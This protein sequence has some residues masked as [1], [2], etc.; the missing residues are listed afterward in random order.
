METLRSIAFV[1]FSIVCLFWF[2]SLAS[3]DGEDLKSRV[4]YLEAQNAQLS[5]RI[6][7]L[8]TRNARLRRDMDEAQNEIE[9]IET[10]L[11]WQ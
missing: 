6:E 7:D 10:A 9:K 5:Y 8:E 11:R 4:D 3:S 1:I 2:W